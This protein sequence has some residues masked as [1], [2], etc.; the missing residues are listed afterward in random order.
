[1]QSLKWVL[2]CELENS[3][4]KSNLFSTLKDSALRCRKTWG[5]PV[6]WNKK[7]TYPVLDPSSLFSQGKLCPPNPE[8]G[9]NSMSQKN[10]GLQMSV[11]KGERQ[12]LSRGKALALAIGLAV[13]ALILGVLAPTLTVTDSIVKAVD[14]ESLLSSNPELRLARRYMAEK[15]VPSDAAF[16]STNPEVMIARRYMAENA[17]PS[18]VTLLSAN[19]ELKILRNYAQATAVNTQNT[20]LA[21]NP[22]LISVQHYAPP[23]AARSDGIEAPTLEAN[24]ELI[25]FRRYVISGSAT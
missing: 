22:E 3:W 1:M 12:S 21:A 5:S 24:P 14:S 4:A 13:V 20:H 19:P 15:T 16:L 18:D 17:A 9:G 6:H 7:L 10:T 25:I 11:L 8:K 2:F 23:K